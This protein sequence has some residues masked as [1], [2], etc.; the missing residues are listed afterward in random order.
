MTTPAQILNQ[1]RRLIIKIGSAL[2]INPADGN[3]RR[4]WLHALAEDVCAL[5]EQGKEIAIVTSGAV[6][7]GRRQLGI[8]LDLPSRSLDLELKQAAAAIGQIDLAQV[9]HNVFAERGRSVGQILLNLT[10]TENRQAHLN[11]RATLNALI[12]N[13]I[14]P[15][16]NENDTT[17]RDVIRF[18]DNDRLAARVSQMIGADT[19]LILSTTDGVYT[20]DPRSNPDA[21]HIP[22]I[23]NLSADIMGFARET[24]SGVST[25]GMKSKLEAAQSAVAGGC[26][27][28]IAD[29]QVLHPVQ[30]L[31]ED[32]KKATIVTAREKTQTARKR[33]IMGHIKPAG[34]VSIDSGA[35]NAL[36]SGKSLLP[37]GIREI[38]GAFE[39][40]DAVS[41]RDPAGV[42]IAVGLCG[43]GHGDTALIA[44]CK[45]QDIPSILGYVGPDEFIHRDDLALM[46]HGS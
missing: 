13:R 40:G 39:R 27:V 1:S 21:K 22:L 41:V 7:L 16:I 18:G 14:I 24:L 9:Y 20:D 43:Y 35:V 34:A 23:D 5:A 15:I 26:T 28:M 38:S 37:A 36:K 42:V 6:A 45:S 32:R 10:D 46:E 29:G 31:A 3:V 33:W 11:A 30:M 25:G 17:A 12:K 2:L 44:G 19:L 8:P 4:G